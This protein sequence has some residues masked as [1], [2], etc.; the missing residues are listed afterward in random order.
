MARK[1]IV[2]T[3]DECQHILEETEATNEEELRSL[4]KDNPDLLP[5]EEFG[6]NGSVMVVG[7]ETTL[8]SGAVD[9]ICV[10]A[11]GD[12][13]VVEFKTGPQNSDFRHSLAQLLHY[14]SDLWHMTYEV[15]E[16]TVAVRYF[17]HSNC[18][19]PRVK[20]K[21]SLGEAVKST[22]PELSEEEMSHFKDHLSRQL[23][24]GG[25]NYVLVASSFTET[26]TRTLEY[27][28]A[29]GSTSDFFGVELVPFSGPHL[30]AFESRTIV[31]P[32]QQSGRSRSGTID[33]SRLLEQVVDER[34]RESLKQLLDLCHGLGLKTSWGT[35]GA[36]IRISIPDTTDLLSIGWVFP[37]GQAGWSGLR[38][39]T[40]GVDIAS[41]SKSPSVKASIDSYM[42]A[43][44]NLNGVEPVSAQ[45]LHAFHLGKDEM[46][47][48]SAEVS[49]II[50]QLVSSVNT[51]ND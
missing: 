30:S 51:A 41:A 37:P 43:L 16:S 32:Y 17:G 26:V 34:Y 36:S 45:G 23:E 38:D 4:V 28:N 2:R 48:L 7:R 14:G 10:T 20:G 44:E 42:S 9:L 31:K 13:L 19:D 1:M 40:L 11:N 5:I 21:T 18:N 3:G 29:L 39:V 25:F 50:A 49:D 47:D 12:L 22:W 27:M 8:A 33:E 46:I 15:F 6:L 35:V 24:G